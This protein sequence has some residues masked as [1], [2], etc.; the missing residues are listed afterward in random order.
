[1]TDQH[2]LISKSYCRYLN[3]SKKIESIR[4]EWIDEY[5]EYILENLSIEGFT[6]AHQLITRVLEEEPGYGRLHLAMATVYEEHGD[7]SQ[8]AIRHLYLAIKFDPMLADAYYKLADLLVEHDRLDEAIKICKRGLKAEQVK[9]AYLLQTAANAY[10]LKHQYKKAIKT[11][12][13]AL[14]H[15]TR[16]WNCLVLEESIER[17][18]R[19]TK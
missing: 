5:I 9:K 1:M 10:E 19:K 2:S 16:T 4:I 3:E 6:K 15:S 7:R 8:F 11:Y 17:C 18:K 14:G 13:D 12:K